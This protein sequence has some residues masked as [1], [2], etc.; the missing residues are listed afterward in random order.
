MRRSFFRK[1][2]SYHRSPAISR[3]G[4]TMIELLVAATI[5]AV[6][7]TIGVVS[8]R[9]ASVKA[10]DGKRSADLNQVR[11]ALEL[12]RSAQTT[13]TYPVTTSFTG[14]TGTLR[15]A[16][17]LSDPLP[18]DPKNVSPYQYTYNGSAAAFC[19]CAQLEQT[20]SGNA[21][22]PSGPSCNFATG[23]NYYCLVNP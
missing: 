21:S 22:A 9:Q 7:T 23:G 1:H 13:S 17:Y 12:Y 6:L 10:R 20:G 19:M 15:T 4:F 18:L 14:M 3:L 8:F 16:G 11:A 5:I 2:T